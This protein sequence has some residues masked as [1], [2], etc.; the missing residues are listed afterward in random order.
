MV[1]GTPAVLYDLIISIE[2]KT[3]PPPLLESNDF[4]WKDK[5][6]HSLYY[7][8]L[9]FFQADV[10]FSLQL[11]FQSLLRVRLNKIY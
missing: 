3:Q 9:Y 5:K 1:C 6:N 11:P 8:Q 4:L 10:L 7:S 2:S